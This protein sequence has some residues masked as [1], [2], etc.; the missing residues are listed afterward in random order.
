MIFNRVTLRSPFYEKWVGFH[1]SLANRYGEDAGDGTYSLTSYPSKKTRMPNH[2][3]I[4]D[5]RQQILL[6]YFMAL[7]KRYLKNG[8][9]M[10]K[11]IMLKKLMIHTRTS[12]VGPSP[13]SSLARSGRRSPHGITSVTSKCDCAS[14]VVIGTRLWAVKWCTDWSTVGR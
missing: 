13:S 14:C 1:T 10:S 8:G 2:L 7:S 11:P 5:Q 3:R 4:T 6:T 9:K 12:W